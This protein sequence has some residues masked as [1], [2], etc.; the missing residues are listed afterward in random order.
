MVIDKECFLLDI[1]DTSG[2]EENCVFREQSMREGDGFLFVLDVNN[3]VSLDK[4]AEWREKIKRDKGK[5]K[6]R[7]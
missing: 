5:E 2:Q 7:L 1:F 3:T 6:V 4:L